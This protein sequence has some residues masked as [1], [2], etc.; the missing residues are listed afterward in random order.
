[1][2]RTKGRGIAT[3]RRRR[4]ETQTD[5]ARSLHGESRVALAHAVPGILEKL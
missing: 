4:R 5:D 1:M 2:T 3:L